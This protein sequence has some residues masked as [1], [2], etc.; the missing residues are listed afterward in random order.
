MLFVLK[1]WGRNESQK[2]PSLE[3]TSKTIQSI[4]PPTINTSPLYHV[5]KYNI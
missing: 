2:S 3:K 1:N 5:P 4:Y